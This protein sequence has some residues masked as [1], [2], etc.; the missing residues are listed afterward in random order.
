MARYNITSTGQALERGL[1][2]PEGKSLHVIDAT[3]PTVVFS[4]TNSERAGRWQA[5]MEA[6][7]VDK[8]RAANLCEEAKR[9]EQ[10]A[11]REE[12]K[13]AAVMGQEGIAWGQRQVVATLGL[14][15]GAGAAGIAV[16]QVVGPTTGANA[17]YGAVMTLLGLGLAFAMSGRHARGGVALGATLVA[18]GGRHL[19]AYATTPRA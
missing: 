4:T 11:A 1:A 15:M 3:G 17:A 18:L 7:D 6:A 14:G 5:A 10:E 19:L 8:Q 2:V 16:D 13:A 9:I 12:A